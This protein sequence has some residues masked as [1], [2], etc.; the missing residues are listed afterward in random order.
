MLPGQVVDTIKG[1]TLIGP[2]DHA[3]WHGYQHVDV[4]TRTQ[5]ALF[6]SVFLLIIQQILVDYSRKDG[7]YSGN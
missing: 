3:L 1:R 5:R 7:K 2:I 6:I 4:V